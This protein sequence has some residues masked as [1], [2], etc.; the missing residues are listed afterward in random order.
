MSER[1][2]APPAWM[3]A[4]EYRA[5]SERAQMSALLPM[6]RRL[7]SGDGHPV[8]VLPGFT[9]SDRSTVPLRRL[10]R[11]L[12]YRTYGWG[13]GANVGPT[14][15]ILEGIFGRLDRAY[16]RNGRPVSLIGWSLGGIYARE[17]ARARPDLVRQVIT[18]GSPIQMIDDDASSA[19][20]VWESLKKYHVKD[21]REQVREADRPRIQVPCTSI[22]T[23]T[24]GVVNWKASLIRGSATTENI[25]VYGSHCGL[26]FN[27]AAIVA[28]ADRLAQPEGEWAPF[29]APWYLRGAFPC[30]T[31]LDRSKLP[32]AAVA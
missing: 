5:V 1:I 8:L 15:R 31:D 20:A 11:D 2:T 24:D 19:T 29:R 25:R 4:L 10:L 30:A 28:I 26:G 14:N 12:E 13:L 17:L 3:A 23:K 27:T 7:P 32:P 22:Y 16:E 9:A 18:L 6:L 21:F